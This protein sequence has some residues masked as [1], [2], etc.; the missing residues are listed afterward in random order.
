MN[1]T[2]CKQSILVRYY[3]AVS[4]AIDDLEPALTRNAITAVAAGIP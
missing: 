2:K 3:S 4:C 1:A